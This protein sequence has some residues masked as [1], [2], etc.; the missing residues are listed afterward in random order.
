VAVVRRLPAA[1][2]I[3]ELQI[4]FEYL[5]YGKRT[6]NVQKTEFNIPSFYFYCSGPYKNL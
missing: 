2:V 3:F 1:A 5:Q 4:K 6:A